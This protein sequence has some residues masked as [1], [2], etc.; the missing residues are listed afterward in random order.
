MTNEMPNEI[1]VTEPVKGTGTGT[2]FYAQTDFDGSTKYIRADS[3]HADVAGAL[4]WE[5]DIDILKTNIESLPKQAG[6]TAEEIAILL[7]RLGRL[8]SFIRAALKAQLQVNQEL[9]KAL[10]KAA[11]IFRDYERIHLSKNPPD[12]SKAERNGD[13]A[14]MV[15][16]AIARAKQKGLQ[17]GN[18]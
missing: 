1:Y 10:K 5:R 3:I 14:Y 18:D 11:D 16:Q 9:L 8:K 17:N 15:E 4:D 2:G 7:M 6:L 12:R 13:Y